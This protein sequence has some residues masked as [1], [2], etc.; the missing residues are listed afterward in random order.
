M[1][2]LKGEIKKNVPISIIHKNWYNPNIQSPEIYQKVKDV[3]VSDGM[4]LKD[5]LKV[6]ICKEPLCELAKTEFHYQLVD[7]EH[8]Y[9]AC[10]ELG[11]QTIDILD[12]GEMS[13]DEARRDT[14]NF[15]N[16]RGDDD[17]L[18]RAKMYDKMNPNQLALL[19]FSD[20]QI[21]EEKNLLQFD[22]KQ[23][24][25]VD[26]SENLV[27]PFAVI[28]GTA[29]KLKRQILEVKER[30]KD[31][32]T[33]L[34]CLA[35]VDGLNQLEDKFLVAKGKIDMIPDPNQTSMFEPSTT[36]NKLVER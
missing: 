2:S 22:F 23:F 20:K 30:I 11:I 21:S 25:H 6:R 27:S 35:I 10:K 29:I 17:P 36:E 12:L 24:D 34:L 5:V 28:V 13:D 32:P 7:G 4:K 31:E 9:K 1:G 26:M 3:I 8:R 33:W 16:L 15:N 18:K 14:L 19:A